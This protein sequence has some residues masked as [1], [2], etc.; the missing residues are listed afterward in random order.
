MTV[1]LV[2]SL[3]FVGYKGPFSSV[4]QTGATIHS[5]F[6]RS[7]ILAMVSTAVRLATL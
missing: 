6:A 1:M 5:C 2:V 7:L 3:R 4:H